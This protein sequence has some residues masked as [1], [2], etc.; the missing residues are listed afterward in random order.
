VSRRRRSA[1]DSGSRRR[2]KP[3]SRRPASGRRAGRAAEGDI[4]GLALRRR[5]PV[6]AVQ[7]RGLADARLA[8]QHQGAGAAGAGARDEFVERVTL[9]LAPE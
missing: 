6:E 3:S 1:G 7:Q 4:E 2:R 9:D 8:A 5:E